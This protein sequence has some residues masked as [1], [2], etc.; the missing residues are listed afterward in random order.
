[1]AEFAI[2][3]GHAS[4]GT[5]ERCREAAPS[6]DH[7]VMLSDFLTDRED[8]RYALD[9]G[10]FVCWDRGEHWI[11]SGRAEKFVRMLRRATEKPVQPDFVILP[12]VVMEPHQTLRRSEQW[13]VIIREEFG[14]D[15]PL[16]LSCQN[17]MNTTRILEAADR[18]G[19]DGLFV[20]GDDDFKKRMVP[21]LAPEDYHIH[22]G[23]PGDLVWAKHAGVDS[24]DTTSIAQSG[25]YHRL[26]RLE[27]QTEL[28]VD[29]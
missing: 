10:A 20:G 26:E 7:R 24:V 18:L 6:V 17:G 22:V 29:D 28:V 4:D 11:K 27:E 12:D 14:L 2:Y 25:S 15:F 3:H 13:A 23:R 9:N 8:V 19:V 16:F 5:L 21:L 1:M